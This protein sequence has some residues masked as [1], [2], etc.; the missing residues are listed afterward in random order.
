LT[1]GGSMRSSLHQARS[2]AFFESVAAGSELRAYSVP[3]PR[4]PDP[5]LAIRLSRQ[6]R[7]LAG[8]GRPHGRLIETLVGEHPYAAPVLHT[9]AWKYLDPDTSDLAC[10]NRLYQECGLRRSFCSIEEL[11]NRFHQTRTWQVGPAMDEIAR[12]VLALRVA[13]HADHT[14]AIVRASSD[15]ASA[16]LLLTGCPYRRAASREIWL[17]CGKAFLKKNKKLNL[18]FE[19]RTW[20]F[21]SDHAMGVT[22]S[23][24]LMAYVSPL[25]TELPMQVVEELLRDI[26]VAV[27]TE[28]RNRA[29]FIFSR[30][31]VMSPKHSRSLQPGDRRPIRLPD[32]D[33]LSIWIRS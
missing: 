14:A 3:R 6:K 26:V 1:F 5:W 22:T 10:E 16:L 33:E 17:H 21:I 4:T 13:S 12:R 28:D 20:E 31:Q 18:R 30:F 2:V 9:D 25:A 11:L 8:I 15:L 27:T 23:F 32:I 24:R 19:A 7:Y 29:D